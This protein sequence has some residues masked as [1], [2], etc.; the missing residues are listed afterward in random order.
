MTFTPIAF[1]TRSWHTPL[2]AA[3]QDLQDQIT[4]VDNGGFTPQDHGL[5]AWTHDPYYSD[6][7]ATVVNG[8]VYVNKL[9]IRRPATLNTLGWVVQNGATTPTAGQNWVGLYSSAGSKLVETGVD[10]ASSSAGTKLTTITA[11]SV[12]AGFIWAAFLF[13]AATPPLILKGSGGTSSPNINLAAAVR[14]SAVAATGQTT[15]PASFTPS[16]LSLTGNQTLFA[17]V[18]V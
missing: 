12:T 14:R 17:A 18:A 15:L 4:V 5:E 1:G 16:A 2:N 6:K 10:S 9:M 3:L 7:D 13:N 11:Q 8:T